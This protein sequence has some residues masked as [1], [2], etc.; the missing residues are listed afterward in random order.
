MVHFIP[1][2]KPFLGLEERELLLDAYDSG[3]ISSKGKYVTEFEQKYSQFLNVKYGV[4]VSNGTAALHLALS[5]LGIGPGDKVV[6]PTFSFISTAN[7]IRYTGAEPVF[8]DSDPKYW[9]MDPN[10]IE[11]K[12]DKNTKAIMPVHIYG[13]PCDM[14]KILELS[15]KYNLYVIEDAAE[16]HGAQYKNKYVGTFGIISCFSF[17]G[18]KIITTGEGGMCTTNNSELYDKMKIL[19]DHG[20][21][22]QKKYY[23]DFIGY[24]YRMTNLQAAIGVAQLKKI[25]KIID[26][27]REIARIYDQFFDEI[28]NIDV[29][30]EMPWA[31]SVYWLY[32]I[33]VEK[34]KNKIIKKLFEN[35]IES[36]PFFYPLNLQ[37]PYR[38]IT[39]YSVAE[40]ISKKG[41]NLPSYY[42][43][44]EEDIKFICRIIKT[45]L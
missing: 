2:S 20:M 33:L 21:N 9:C 10:K 42:D 3:W 13:H 7:V 11:E 14:E 22:P 28:K 39:K 29:Q 23:H 40:K 36:R 8:I 44:T 27:K 34:N 17:Y 38:T 1:I 43:L 5:S 45:S 37:P 32:S 16:A 31:K 18:N 35:K 15:E 12:I 4:S 30:H 26:R 19:R 25:N 6:V 41:I 24:N